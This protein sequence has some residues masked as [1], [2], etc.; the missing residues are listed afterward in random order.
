MVTC[1]E[2]KDKRCDS[3]KKGKAIKTMFNANMQGSITSQQKET[4]FLESILTNPME[5]FV[6]KSGETDQG[7]TSE[8]PLYGMTNESNEHRCVMAFVSEAH[9]RRA[10]SSLLCWQQSHAVAINITNT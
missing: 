8:W 10:L 4:I 3:L 6:S 9:D 5:F 1:G 7:K 2:I